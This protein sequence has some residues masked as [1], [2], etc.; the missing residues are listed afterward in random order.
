VASAEN[1][2]QHR[3]TTV[4]LF[5]FQK[6]HESRSHDG[7]EIVDQLHKTFL[8]PFSLDVMS[9][10]FDFIDLP[11]LRNATMVNKIW[12][13]LTRERFCAANPPFNNLQ[14]CDYLCYVTQQQVVE[15]QKKDKAYAEAKKMKKQEAHNFAE[16][17]LLE[18]TAEDTRID[19]IFATVKAMRKYLK[20]QG[21]EVKAGS[22]E[23]PN[24]CFNKLLIIANEQL[25]ET[26]ATLDKI[27]NETYVVTDNFD[28][29]ELTVRRYYEQ[30]RAMFPLRTRKKLAAPAQLITDSKARAV[31]NNKVGKDQHHCEFDKFYQEAIC[32]AFPEL[33]S[34]HECHYYFS[35]FLNF[36]QDNM[37]TTYKW[38]VLTR[39]F[40]PYDNFMEN[41]KTYVLGKGFLGLINRIC[42][43]EIL[44][45]NPK[46]V[47]MR[48]SRTYPTCLAFSFRREDDKFDHYTN[49]PVW[50]S[51]P[52][53][54]DTRKSSQMKE[55]IPIKEFLQKV[56]F[57]KGYQLVPKKVDGRSVVNS[58]S[59]SLYASQT[60]AYLEEVDDVG[61]LAQSDS[62][63]GSDDEGHRKKKNKKKKKLDKKKH[64]TTLEGYLDD[65]TTAD[66]EQPEA[67]KNFRSKETKPDS[68][69]LYIDTVHDSYKVETT[70]YVLSQDN[71]SKTQNFAEVSDYYAQMQ[72]KLPEYHDAYY[73]PK[74]EEKPSPA[75][76]N[77]LEDDLAKMVAAFSEEKPE[78]QKKEPSADPSKAGFQKASGGTPP[79]SEKKP[80][81][82]EKDCQYSRG[83]DY[84]SE[85]FEV[86]GYKVETPNATKQPETRQ[87]EKPEAPPERQPVNI[88]KELEAAAASYKFDDL[89]DCFEDV[90]EEIEKRKAQEE[91]E[92]RR[93][94]EK[95]QDKKEQKRQKEEEKK[96]QEEKEK[97]EK[98]EEEEKK[99][100][101]KMEKKRQKEEEKKR[102]EEKEKREKEE[103][104]EKK[105]QAKMEKKRQKEEQ[106]K[107]QEEKEKREKEE[108]EEKKR[109]EKKR[110]KKEEDE[111]RV[112]QMRLEEEK[113]KIEEEEK[114]Q[115]KTK[116][117]L[118]EERMHLEEEKKQLQEAERKRIEEEV[119]K[120]L[121]E[122]KRKLEEERK[123]V[124]EAKRK[125]G[126]EKKMR[127][128]AGRRTA[129]QR[130][131]K[132]PHAASGTISYERLKKKDFP[133]GTDTTKLETLLSEEEFMGVFCMT[134]KDFYNM[135]EWKQSQL[136]RQRGLF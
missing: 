65:P 17:T 125:F 95:K 119:L 93:E 29:F 130:D 3:P 57:D 106:K 104:E 6:M 90:D 66:D 71:K 80:K 124:A 86:E 39:L 112:L 91:E 75:S 28:I 33:A 136:K 60:S 118:E 121:E 36:P 9:I 102:Q 67:S 96:R 105:K 113:R 78:E 92:K 110:L 115:E 4:F 101:A 10:I 103:E 116:K 131:A 77:Y 53:F 63:S 30:L 51:Y 79:K 84:F 111:Q 99:K 123:Q 129:E 126:E 18:Y 47:L 134:R 98:E 122:E 11:T 82:V 55:N 61:Y 37:V 24:G 8:G 74:A 73:V 120:K 26:K 16:D 40:G 38:E 46:C 100:Q 107:I 69:E 25:R 94:K 12:R 20:K 114:R 13:R 58:S 89:T 72:T 48:L 41:F 34:N 56:F 85:D 68:L 52:P 76:M 64:T 127:Q 44:K 45:E 97:R 83:S 49:N 62:D 5:P 50:N 133:A 2:A 14:I 19:Y 128:E 88:A 59:V 108:E 81:Q 1:G 27:L 109:A 132:G 43:E 117:Q 23:D 15:I 42:A 31:W 35:Y 22:L 54:K 7:I 21:A 135:R 70:L 32:N 87:S